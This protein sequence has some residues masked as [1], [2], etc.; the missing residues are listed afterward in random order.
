[1]KKLSMTVKIVIA[2][3]VVILSFSII[4]RCTTPEYIETVKEVTVVDSTKID[5]LQQRVQYLESIPPD[6]TVVEIP[7]PTPTIEDSIY[8]YTFPFRDSLISSVTRVWAKDEITDYEFEYY[9]HA[10]A[11]NKVTN[12]IT[13]TV[14]LTTTKTITKTKQSRAYLSAG[15]EV[16]INPQ[17]NSVSP[18]VSYTMQDGQTFSFRYD[19]LNQ[20]Y[21]VSYQ[22][23]IRFKLPF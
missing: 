15:L 2:V 5:S 18:K 11:V 4:Q 19:V 9:Y 20:G 3:I 22:R 7:I 14:H 1:M 12:T 10:R 23:S 6:T 13:E 17:F 21:Y 8:K 16:G